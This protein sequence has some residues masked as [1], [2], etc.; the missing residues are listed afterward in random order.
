MSFEFSTDGL[1]GIKTT[2]VINPAS[3]G[4]VTNGDFEAFTTTDIPD[5][6]TVDAG[7]ATTDFGEE[8]T[9]I[10]RGSSA[11]EF[12][13]SAT[14]VELSQALS[15]LKALTPYAVNLYGRKEGTVSAGVMTVDLY[16]GTSV[17]NDE[18]GTANSFTIDLSTET[19]SYAAENAVFRLPDPIRST[20]QLRVRITTAITVGGTYL[21]DDVSLSQMAQV[22]AG[23]P[24]VAMFTGDTALDLDDEWVITVTN[25]YRGDWQTWFWRLFGDGYKLPSNSA[26]AETVA[27]SLIG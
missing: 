19:T 8:T 24:F 21:I 23:G 2:T 17:I 18:A 20:V 27:D 9:N 6:W 4:K 3:A 10:Y 12:K 5:N 1:G 26:G 14:L 25:D 13:T 11:L 16:D 15:G 7:T 22:Y